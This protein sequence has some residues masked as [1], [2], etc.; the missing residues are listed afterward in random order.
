[1]CV[2][3]SFLCSRAWEKRDGLSRR[4]FHMSLQSRCLFG[5]SGLLKEMA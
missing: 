3:A 5:G 1:M 2:T 4:T